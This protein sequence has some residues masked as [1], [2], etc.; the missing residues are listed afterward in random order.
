MQDCSVVRDWGHK[1]LDSTVESDG[2]A[3]DLL[4]FLFLVFGL[5]FQCFLIII[6]H[7]WPIVPPTTWEGSAGLWRLLSTVCG[8]LTDLYTWW[9]KIPET[10]M[11]KY[12]IH[13]PEIRGY[14]HFNHT[15]SQQPRS[16]SSVPQMFT[17][18]HIPHIVQTIQTPP[19]KSLNAIAL[20]Y[21][22]V[23]L[24]C[25]LKANTSQNPRMA[26]SKNDLSAARAYW[27]DYFM[28]IWL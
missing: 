24:M 27:S 25:W 15:T 4:I 2:A 9:L 18:T 17:C 14:V 1:T 5:R 16:C 8:R 11:A 21:S 10:I 19:H 13:S 7:I 20:V 22:A 6:H 23:C 28:L 3:T 26:K 12:N